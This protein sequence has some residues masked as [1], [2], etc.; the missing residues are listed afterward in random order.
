MKLYFFHIPKIDPDF[1]NNKLYLQ[2]EFFID[3]NFTWILALKIPRIFSNC[4]ARPKTSR[5]CC[6]GKKK[7]DFPPP[8]DRILPDSNQILIYWATWCGPCKIELERFQSAV[9]EGSLPPNNVWALNIENPR[10]SWSGLC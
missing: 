1:K 3:F 2:L 6:I 7:M 5:N 10:N 8:V 4:K 9:N